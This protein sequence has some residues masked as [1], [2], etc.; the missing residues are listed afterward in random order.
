[1]GLPGENMMF[2]EKLG[3]RKHSL[4]QTSTE[5][6]IA[7]VSKLSLDVTSELSKRINNHQKSTENELDQTLPLSKNQ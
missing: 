5:S 2:V 4:D 6:I 7:E 1:M 3:A